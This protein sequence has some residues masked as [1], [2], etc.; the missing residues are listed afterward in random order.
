MTLWIY[1][2]LQFCLYL[3][4][5]TRP[6]HLQCYSSLRFKHS[7]NG[8]VS[9]LPRAVVNLGWLISQVPGA[10]WLFLSLITQI[11]SVSG[12]I[13]SP[14]AKAVWRGLDVS[15]LIAT[16]FKIQIH[17][18]SFPRSCDS[19]CNF[20][21]AAFFL[22]LL[23]PSLSRICQPHS[24]QSEVSFTFVFTELSCSLK[25]LFPPFFKYYLRPLNLLKYPINCA[26]I[27]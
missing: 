2:H 1:F 10:H 27:F 3:P 15:I 22:S 13:K 7:H 16:I 18:I 26:N 11:Q 21:L 5:L 14:L 4:L 9:I 6:V 19:S 20:S 17:F 8:N 23:A 24:I 25:H 12:L